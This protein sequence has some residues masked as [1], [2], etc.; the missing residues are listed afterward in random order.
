MLNRIYI[1]GFFM[2]WTNDFFSMQGARETAKEVKGI[3]GAFNSPDA[4]GMAEDYGVHASTAKNREAMYAFFQK[5]LNNPGSSMDEEVIIPEAEDLRVSPTGQVNTSFVTET[6][7]SLNSKYANRLQNEMNETGK[8]LKTRIKDAVSFAREIS[9]YQ[10]PKNIEKPVYAGQIIREGYRI[11]RYFL[12]GEGDYVIPYLLMIP[13]KPNSKVLLYLHPEGK[14]AEA[15]QGGEM[16]WFIQNGFSVMAPDLIGLGETGPGTF[17]GDAYIEGV[18]FNLVFAANL[19]GRSI[20]GIRAGDV[21]RLVRVLKETYEFSEIHTL[22]KGELS[23]VLLHAAAFEPEIASVALTEP[24]SSYHSL[25]TS[26]YY[27]TSYTH[28]IVPGSHLFYDLPDLAAA[29]APR[30]LFILNSVDANGIKIS[31]EESDNVYSLVR[32]AYQGSFKPGAFHIMTGSSSDELFREWIK[33][34]E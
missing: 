30:R 1:M 12:Q 34:L 7:Y 5:H 4:F 29:I 17:R 26:Q 10:E 19:I 21:A 23:P 33:S 3:Y 24:L 11:E 22:A 28:S 13:E 20:L 2:D 9:G 27:S 31:K 32:N 8:D 18:S 6:I 16:E 14:S 25:V 15:M